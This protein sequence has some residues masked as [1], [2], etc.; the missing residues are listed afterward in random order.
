MRFF[1]KHRHVLLMAAG[2]VAM[3]V[4]VLALTT[5][6]SGGGSGLYLLLLLCPAVHILMHRGMHGTGNRQEMPPTQLPTPEKE[7]PVEAKS[8]PSE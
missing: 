7:A 3:L 8:R 4:A 6:P 1:H 5:K 2:C